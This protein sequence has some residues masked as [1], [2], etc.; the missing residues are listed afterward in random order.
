MCLEYLLIHAQR[1]KDK[2]PKQQESYQS[3]INITAF[4]L[5]RKVMP[6]HINKEYIRIADKDGADQAQQQ[7]I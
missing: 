6:V 1:Q 7:Y 3:A 5:L 2:H 4:N